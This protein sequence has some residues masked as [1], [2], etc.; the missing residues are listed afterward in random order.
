MTAKEF[1]QQVFEAY[2]DADSKLEQIDRLQSLAT[3]TTSVIRNTPI[4]NSN[5]L[6][7]RIE[8][9]ICAVAGQ[10]EKLSEEIER[11]LNVRCEVAD[12]IAKISNPSERRILEYRY[13]AF[14][15][16]RE[17]S[18]AMKTGLRTIY[19]LL[20]CALKNFAA[21]HQMSLFGSQCH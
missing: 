10:N 15:S 11:L 6:S 17:I 20:D 7:S 16:W 3:R 8:Q 9:A 4:G 19:R 12:A 2:K 1:L 21:C 14:M 18:Q 13:L 5:G